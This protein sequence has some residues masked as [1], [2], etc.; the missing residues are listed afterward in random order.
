[1]S[2]IRNKICRHK[3]THHFLMGCWRVINWAIRRWSGWCHWYCYLD[4]YHYYCY[5]YYLD[6]Y[7]Y[8]MHVCVVCYCTY[9]CM[10]STLS[11]YVS[12]TWCCVY[13]TFLRRST[14]SCLSCILPLVLIPTRETCT[15]FSSSLFNSLLHSFCIISYW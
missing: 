3:I 7:S 6:Y 14:W 9:T 13:I 11:I 12:W 4:H 8:C 10:W 1:M 2:E 15:G 5:H